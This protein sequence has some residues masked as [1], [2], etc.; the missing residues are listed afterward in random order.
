MFNTKS[1]IDELKQSKR[2]ALENQQKELD[3]LKLSCKEIFKG[4]NGI[5]ILKFLKN[6]CLW[7]SENTNIDKDLLAYRSG[8]RDIWL[9]LRSLLPKDVLAQVEI[10]DEK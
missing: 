6:T 2:K 10:Y 9:I 7:D 5:Y 8:R 1:K 4:N 3:N